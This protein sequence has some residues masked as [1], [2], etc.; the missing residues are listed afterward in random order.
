MSDKND[1]SI[2][3]KMGASIKIKD[4]YVQASIKSNLQPINHKLDFPS[5]GVTHFFSDDFFLN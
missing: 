4:G 3:E 1:K 5:V 2:L